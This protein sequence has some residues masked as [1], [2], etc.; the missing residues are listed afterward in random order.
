MTKEEQVIKML[1]Q[2]SSYRVIATTLHISNHRIINIKERLAERLKKQGKDFNVVVTNIR[3]AKEL[4]KNKDINRIE[5]NAFRKY[6]RLENAVAEYSK[7]L[8]KAIKKIK[9]PEIKPVKVEKP[10]TVG[11]AQFTDLHLNELVELPHNRFDFTIAAKRL[12][13]YVISAKEYLK[14]KRVN[15]LL[16]G[17]TGDIINSDRRPDEMLSMATNRAK[18]TI[19]S[20]VLLEQVIADFAKDFNVTVAGVVGNESRIPKE[21]GWTEIV[22]SDNYDW[23]VLNVIKLL[24]RNQPVK[25]ISG[26][27]LEKVIRLAGQ[28]IL[29]IHGNQINRNHPEEDVQ[30][31]QGKYTAQGIKIDFVAFGHYHSSAI[32]DVFARGAS[33]VG[34]NAYSSSALLYETRASQPLHIFYRSGN[35]D[36]IKI[37]LQEVKGIK[38]YNI[39]QELLEHRA[40]NAVTV[41]KI[42]IKEI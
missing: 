21:L 8:L 12:K 10:E 27:S 42:S 31:I 5:R 4:Q 25:F 38:G 37:D 26:N 40:K 34:A 17:F 7:E 11:F 19:I 32:G 30:R 9:I 6:A 13:K 36:S 15:K 14:T 20:I 35:R 3:L 33:L 28:N 23:T 1:M 39:Q 24:F 18:A 22:A 16:I 41:K 2:G 29:L